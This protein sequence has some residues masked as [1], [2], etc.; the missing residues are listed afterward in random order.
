MK[1]LQINKYFPP[2]IGGVESVV[3][4]YADHLS[5]NNKVR[6][7]VCNDTTG[8]KTYTTKRE[9][10]TVTF[11]RTLFI[12]KKLPI[13]IAFI[14]N[15]I[16]F[17]RWADVVHIHEPF[18]LGSILLMLYS[19]KKTILI[20]WHSDIVSQKFLGMIVKPIQDIIL[21]KSTFTFTTSENLARH[22]AQLSKIKNKVK[23]L[24]LSINTAIE[25][26]SND[27][28]VSTISSELAHLNHFC[29]SF[30][31]LSYY[32]GIDIL[33]K[34]YMEHGA[35]LPPLVIAGK[36]EMSS[37]IIEA[38]KVVPHKIIFIPRH[39]TEIEKN[40]LLSKCM[41][42][43]FPSTHASE[44]FGITQLEAMI[45][46]K[47]VINTLL[48]TGVPWV[49]IDGITGISVPA[50]DSKRLADAIYRLYN[51]ENLRNNFGNAAHARVLNQFSDKIILNRLSDFYAALKITVELKCGLNSE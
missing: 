41:F 6:V 45:H 34:A 21:R 37:L 24:P 27:F 18:P 46:S 33:A 7:L 25:I 29:L 39:L 19:R 9:K 20:T 50:G 11:C 17:L 44:A 1:I 26:N 49:S 40:A 16:R 31:R 35:M 23:I 38:K 15:Y 28:D 12:L 36:G 8:I 32:K 2:H 14:I 10:Y 47:P 42:F 22:S 51:D 43:V 4:L 5:L 30:G 3:E 13:S 48:P